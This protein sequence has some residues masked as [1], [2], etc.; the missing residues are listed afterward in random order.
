[1]YM[2]AY[3]GEEKCTRAM[4]VVTNK[5]HVWGL[6]FRPIF[7]LCILG[8]V[9]LVGVSRISFFVGCFLLINQ[10]NMFSNILNHGLHILA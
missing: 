4:D 8:C 1:M 7:L 6:G 3:V 2:L 9:M 10:Q 5:I